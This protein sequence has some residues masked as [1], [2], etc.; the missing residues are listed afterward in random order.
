MHK[1]CLIFYKHISIHSDG[2]LSVNYTNLNTLK[3]NKNLI[4]YNKD[5]KLFKKL[6]KKKV[7][8]RKTNKY[9][10]KIF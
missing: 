9:R 2:C 7:S 10:N 1:S 5:Y 6:L 4:I 8:I 3:Q